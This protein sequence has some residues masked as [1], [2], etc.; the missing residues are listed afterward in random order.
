[1]A[2]L[3]GFAERTARA[4]VAAVCGTDI[5]LNVTG[6]GSGYTVTASPTATGL[7]GTMSTAFS[8]AKG[9]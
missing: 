1:M 5:T 9:S 8:V 3:E 4:V 6:I 2:R 7:A